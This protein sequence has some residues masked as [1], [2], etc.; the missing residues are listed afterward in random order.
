MKEGG[1][2]VTPVGVLAIDALEVVDPA[3]ITEADARRAGHASRDDVLEMLA[4]KPTGDVYRV[5][6]HVAGEDPRIALRER[7]ELSAERRRPADEA[8]RPPRCPS[9]R[10]RGR[11]VCCG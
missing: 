11:S 5:T 2:L 7:A 9:R 8:A 4:Q 10:V 3:T 6:F 1:T